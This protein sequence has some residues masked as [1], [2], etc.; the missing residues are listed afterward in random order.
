MDIFGINERETLIVN[1]HRQ[2]GTNK[3]FMHFSQS[4]ANVTW[5]LTYQQA[6]FSNQVMLCKLDLSLMAPS[7]MLSQLLHTLKCSSILDKWSY[8]C[9][10]T[11]ATA[12]VWT[13]LPQSYFCAITHALY[14]V[15][16]CFPTIVQQSKS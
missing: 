9:A 14:S 16:I 4:P 12:Y 11:Q 8:S 2:C 3:W 1:G 7:P 13:A 6:S 10:F 5:D 15:Q